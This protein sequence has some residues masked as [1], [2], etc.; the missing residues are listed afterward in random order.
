MI[1][2]NVK[3]EGNDNNLNAEGIYHINYRFLL[4]ENNG[5]EFNLK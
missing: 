4:Q 1:K 2:Y 3:R 5:N